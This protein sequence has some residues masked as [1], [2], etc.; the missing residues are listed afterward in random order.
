MKHKQYDVELRGIG[1]PARLINE[2]VHSKKKVAKL[3]KV[4]GG[5]WF[6]TDAK[7][8]EY[9]RANR[10]KFNLKVHIV[11]LSDG[12]PI[13][14]LF[15]SWS[16]LL[17]C[18]IPF[19]ASLF[20]WQVNVDAEHPEIAERIEQKLKKSDVVPMQLLRK[21]PDEGTIRSLLMTDEPDLSWVRFEKRGAILTIIPMHSPK[22]TEKI[23]KANK[24]SELAARTGGV[25]TGFQL[26]SGERVARINQTVKQGDLLATGVLEQGDKVSVV[27]AEGSVFADYWLEY[28]FVL[29]KTIEYRA[30]GE[31][32]MSLE[33]NLPWLKQS[34]DSQ[35]F[36]KIVTWKE[37]QYDQVKTITLEEG[38]EKGFLV[39]LL[40][41]KL[42]SETSY[43]KDIKDENILQVTFDNDKV[44]GTILF[45]INEN[46]AMKRPISQGGDD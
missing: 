24:P 34:S 41:H 46:I 17:L 25:I 16:V 31:K 44:T 14:R 11:R 21:L 13:S 5:I 37:E 19:A 2:M 9:I 10:R 42:L 40:K 4:D 23:E 36:W 6:Q 33:W 27:G 20:L 18:I 1:E 43:E 12:T 32:R 22:T 39:P 7:G 28:K 38:M 8:I 30:A 3:E 15:H 35:P 29:P 26:K 45:L